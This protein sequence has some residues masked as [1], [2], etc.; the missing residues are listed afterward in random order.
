MILSENFVLRCLSSI[1]RPTHAGPGPAHC[2]NII[3][4]YYNITFHAEI[5]RPLFD[6]HIIGRNGQ[7]AN[8]SG[9]REKS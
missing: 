9:L 1:V 6:V 2:N 4:K 3:I 7:T 8:T 5:S